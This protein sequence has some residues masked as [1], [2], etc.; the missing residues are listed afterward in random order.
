MKTTKRR[1]ALFDHYGS[2]QP[3]TPFSGSQ[4]LGNGILQLQGL[5]GDTTTQSRWGY[6]PIDSSR[7]L[8]I[9]IDG[10]QLGLLFLEAVSLCPSRFG[11]EQLIQESH[12]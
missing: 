5:N 2:P 3:A 12:G 1:G 7:T 8:A 4:D 11:L 6:D 10:Q 9:E